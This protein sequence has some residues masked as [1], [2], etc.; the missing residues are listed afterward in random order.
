M[1]EELIGIIGADWRLCWFRP[2]P[3]GAQRPPAHEA[4]AWLD[5]T[6]WWQARDDGETLRKYDVLFN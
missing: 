2:W 6:G 3:R 5:S 1:G 4:D